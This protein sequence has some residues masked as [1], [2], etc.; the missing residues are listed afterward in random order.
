VLSPFK[1]AADLVRG[2]A[3]GAAGL[4]ESFWALNGI[5][6]DVQHG[7]VIGIIGRNGA[8]KSTL[9]KVLSRITEPTRGEARIYGRVGSLLEVGTGFHQELTGRENVFLNG[10]ILGMKRFEIARKFDEIVSFSG[11]EKFIDKHYSSGMKV[12]LAFAVAAHLDPEILI[13]DE[14]LAVGDAAFQR[15]CMN[16]MEE[17]GR[18]GRTVLF[19]SH[20]M[21]TVTRLCERTILLQNGEIID[22]GP[23]HA[24]V[25]SYMRSSEGTSASRT[26]GPDEGPRSEITRLRGVHVRLHNGEIAEAIDVRQPFTL[27][28]EFEV[29]KPGYSLVPHFSVHNM[30]GVYVMMPADWDP[31]WR[32]KPRPVGCYTTSIQIPGNLMNEGTYV[33]GAAMRTVDPDIRHFYEADAVAFHMMD[34]QPGAMSSRGDFARSIPG[35]VRPL[36]ETTTQY[37]PT[38]VEQ[39]VSEP[40]L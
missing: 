40:V 35:I 15:K 23:S 8:G 9:L 36:F 12:R 5:S 26:W 25:S 27:E 29:L 24:V 16:K 32:G 38:E 18:Q 11:V 17:V 28:M 33:V 2:Q 19:V 4:S 10:A 6:F 3:Y 1:R 22:D 30:E 20:N 14:V 39:P 37:V 31:E 7:E 21:T 34:A 13:V